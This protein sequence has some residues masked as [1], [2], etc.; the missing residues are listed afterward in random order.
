MTFTELQC[1]VI[2]LDYHIKRSGIENERIVDF[3]WADIQ[4]AEVDLIKGG[5][6]TFKRVKYFYTE[7][8]NSEYYEGEIG[9]P[10][11]CAMLPDFE[12]IED[13]GGDVLLKNKN[14]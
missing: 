8:A 10:E 5:T 7:Y 3:I 4:G 2:T 12:I 14:L 13:Y 1:D 11:I 6:E 9:L